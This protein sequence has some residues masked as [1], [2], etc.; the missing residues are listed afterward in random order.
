MKDIIEKLSSVSSLVS[1]GD[2]DYP[3]GYSPKKV[4][5]KVKQVEYS[6]LSGG[7]EFVIPNKVYDA[8]AKD[9]IYSVSPGLEKSIEYLRKAGYTEDEMDAVYDEARKVKFGKVDLPKPVT[10][11]WTVLKRN[12]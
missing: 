1:E 12:Y 4:R 3:P 11:T 10:I 6:E 7:L 8:Y 9:T 2:D 5:S